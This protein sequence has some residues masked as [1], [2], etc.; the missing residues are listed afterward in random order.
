MMTPMLDQLSV[1]ASVTRNETGADAAGVG[2]TIVVPVEPLPQPR[3]KTRV[4]SPAKVT[5]PDTRELEIQ[6]MNASI[7]ISSTPDWGDVSRIGK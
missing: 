1:G 6:L 7:L 4:P 3:V 5:A 2:G